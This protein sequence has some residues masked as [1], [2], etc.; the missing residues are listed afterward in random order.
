MK[1][2]IP[3]VGELAILLLPLLLPVR[4]QERIPFVT[5]SNDQSVEL[6]VCVGVNAGIFPHPDP[7]LCHV[8]VV[9]MF[10]HPSLYQCAEGYV[11]DTN[12]LGCVPGD[13]SLCVYVPDWPQV[14]SDHT[15]A[16]HADPNVCWEFVLCAQGEVYQYE[17]AEGEIWSQKDGACLPGDRASCE[18]LDI[19]ATCQERPNFVLPHPTDCLKYRRCLD[20]KM[21]LVDCTRG[22]IF[23]P[24]AGQC[25]VGNTNTCTKVDNPCD[26]FHV[27]W[28]HPNE[29]DLSYS[30][31]GHTNVSV[32][33]CPE[34]DIYGPIVKDCV[35]G[36][37]ETC[38]FAPFERACEGR[39]DGMKVPF[40]DTCTKYV[41]CR[42]GKPTEVHCDVGSIYSHHV[43]FGGSCG[44]GDSAKCSSLSY[45]CNGKPHDSTLEHPNFCHIYMQCNMNK[46]L[47]QNCPAGEIFRADVDTCVPG[48]MDSCTFAPIERMCDGRADGRS[49][50]HP[51]DCRQYVRCQNSHPVLENC[52]PGTIF[53]ARNQTCVA[54]D[55]NTCTRLNDVCEKRP[56]TILPH[57]EGCDLFLICSAGTTLALRCPEGEILHPDTFICVPGS[58]EDC[59]VATA[60]TLSPTVSV[61][62]GRPDGKYTYPEHCYQY[63]NCVGGRTELVS[64]PVGEIFVGAVRD[65][66]P[67][68]QETCVPS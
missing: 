34:R 29:C 59:S 47:V 33:V 14:C 10:E 21:R 58:V 65:C 43:M 45:A 39:R 52:R 32:L 38:E 56:D 62:E 7:V 64:C 20:G 35:P 42:D 44:V 54:G 27:R 9:C 40:P 16:I 31:P 19:E 15:Y 23:D 63:I 24:Q 30:C 12:T 13:R 36:Y 18:P 17:C 4:S 53:Y 66:A 46:V 61:C 5:S 3:T 51:T 57:P 67:G 55:G 60:T 50:P 6:D 22:K 48:D 1:R 37:V 2:T 49:Y 26:V 25:V 41:H 68:N 28:P 11:F 8:Y